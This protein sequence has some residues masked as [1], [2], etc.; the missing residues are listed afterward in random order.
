M[1]GND[2]IPQTYPIF[3]GRLKA[4]SPEPMGRSRRWDDRDPWN[5]QHDWA[6]DTI[7]ASGN[8]G[9]PDIPVHD[10]ADFDSGYGSSDL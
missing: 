8:G 10:E 2:Q 3:T 1:Y 4:R 7:T 5:L 9:R 6:T